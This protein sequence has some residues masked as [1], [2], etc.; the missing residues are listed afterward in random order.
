MQQLNQIVYTGTRTARTPDAPVEEQRKHSTENSVEQPK[1]KKSP[2]MAGRTLDP[3]GVNLCIHLLGE[4][5]TQDA[6]LE[7]QPWNPYKDYQRDLS[8]WNDWG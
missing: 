3:A 1:M 2:K 7:H 6:A 8:S 5:Y 4:V